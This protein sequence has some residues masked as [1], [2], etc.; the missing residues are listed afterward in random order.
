MYNQSLSLTVLRVAH[1]CADTNAASR[2]CRLHTGCLH[3]HGKRIVLSY[4]SLN[5]SWLYHQSA[6]T[7]LH[8]VTASLNAGHLTA[9]RLVFGGTQNC[10]RYIKTCTDGER[11][12][13]SGTGAAE[14]G[15]WEWQV[16]VAS[17]LAHHQIPCT[18][19]GRSLLRQGSQELS[20]D[21][22]Q[23]VEP[24]GSREKE[25]NRE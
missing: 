15:L 23:W 10:N 11:K 16:V 17:W 4:L 22:G 12:G 3:Q 7:Q 25:E 9:D 24:G 21:T 6:I 20:G 18:S 1:C 2:V 8:R 14:E 5:A 13:T 19:S